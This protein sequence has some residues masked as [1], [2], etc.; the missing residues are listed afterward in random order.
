[1]T[2]AGAG[3]FFTTLSK[4]VNNTFNFSTL[5]VRLPISAAVV[6]HSVTSVT[7]DRNFSLSEVSAGLRYLTIFS[8]KKPSRSSSTIGATCCTAEGLATRVMRS[9]SGRVSGVAIGGTTSA[10]AKG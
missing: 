2:S 9:L 3:G 8:C 1:M 4:T 5:T 6:L 7:E 10:R